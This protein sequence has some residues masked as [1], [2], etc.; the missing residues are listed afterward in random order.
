MAILSS[1]TWCRTDGS[2]TPGRPRSTRFSCIDRDVRIAFGHYN[3]EMDEQHSVADGVEN[4]YDKD[5]VR[6]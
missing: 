2:T 6:V 1:W 3:N 4:S 5:V